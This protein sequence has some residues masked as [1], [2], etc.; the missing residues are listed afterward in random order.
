[1][2]RLFSIALACAFVW[3]VTGAVQAQ[4]FIDLSD[5]V[6]GGDGKGTGGG[7]DGNREFWGIDWDN[8]NF[9]GQKEIVIGSFTETDGVNPSP[10]AG[11]DLID[12]VFYINQQD[13]EVNSEGV[14][15]VFQEGDVFGS[16]HGY[17]MSNFGVDFPNTN[18]TVGGITTWESVIGLHAAAGVTFD[19]NEIRAAHG[20]DAVHTLSTFAG[21]MGCD[22]GGNP[23]SLFVIYSNKNGIVDDPFSPG[24]FFR[25][26]VEAN[27]GERYLGPIPAAAEFLTLAAGAT[28]G[29]FCCDGAGFAEPRIFPD[30]DI[31]ACA[32]FSVVPA[33]LNMFQPESRKF[34]AT[35]IDTLGFPEDVSDSAGTTYSSAD[36]AIATVSS[37][38][39]V[40][41]IASGATEITVSNGGSSI[42]VPVNVVGEFLNVSD[43]VAG[44][45]GTGL[46]GGPQ[47]DS[48][49]WAIEPDT[50]EFLFQEEVDEFFGEGN[51]FGQV[52]TVDGE[53]PSPVEGSDF[54]D[55]TLY[56]DVTPL[57]INSEGVLFDWPEND[58]YPIGAGPVQSNTTHDYRQ[59]DPVI[60]IGGT[61]DW[62]SCIG[63][64]SSMG[65]TFDLE[66]LRGE[67]GADKIHTFSTVFGQL[68]NCDCGPTHPASGFVIYSDKDGIVPDPAIAGADYFRVEAIT[69]EGGRYLGRIPEEAEFL[70]LATG[71]ANADFCCDWAGFAEPRILAESEV[72]DDCQELTAGDLLLLQGEQARIDVQCTDARGFKRN[73]S[74]AGAGST[75]SVVPEGIVTV[76]ADGLVSVVA[77]GE[78]DVTVS[79]MG[80]SV[81]SKVIVPASPCDSISVD[82]ASLVLRPGDVTQL[83]VPCIDLLGN[84]RDGTTGLG[85]VY[86]SDSPIVTVNQSGLVTG[87]SLGSANITVTNGDAVATVSA[88]VANFVDLGDVVAGGDGF[89]DGSGLIGDSELV[90]LDIDTGEFVLQKAGGAT[91]DADGINPSPVA[92]SDQVDVVFFIDE[93]VTPINSA[94]VE[95]TFPENDV[96]A[97]SFDIILSNVTHD[98]TLTVGPRDDWGSAVGIHAAAGITFDLDVVRGQIGEK[99]N[100]STFAGM[101]TCDC[102]PMTLYVIFS[103]DSE[104][105]DELTFKEQVNARQGS[106]FEAAIPPEATFL[107]LAAGVADGSFCCDGGGFAEPR[108][109]AVT[110]QPFKRGDANSDGGFDLSDS[111]SV[112]NFLFIGGAAPACMKAADIDDRGSLDL[113][114]G[115]FGL[116]ALFA[117]GPT[118]PAPFDS[119]GTD[120]TPDDLSCEAFNPCQ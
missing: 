90:G 15:I 56:M 96:F 25:I 12:A 20:A 102:D 14:G 32:E 3:G 36:T 34:S 71:S 49:V 112:L 103:N 80:A 115:V 84:E 79:R 110:E 4:G 9:L 86:V 76:D 107:T 93:S 11:S 2:G 6:A 61:R 120:P 29:D 55:V 26:E 30:M 41:S 64:H 38:G 77:V 98:G 17:L 88:T 83:S 99:L 94:G 87:V 52:G 104:V 105:L 92:E 101:Y 57:E 37:T 42:V 1:M 69:A 31:N 54:V 19:L 81:V 22:C 27:Q 85:T 51:N 82:P 65:V 7:P 62:A 95:Y 97:T 53:N 21:E 119:C 68:T 46:G 45:D 78:A 91:S 43:L 63:L 74:A 16:G 117:G 106:Q 28:D 59:G 35:C 116:N 8:G 39:V 58:L 113:T 33:V 114:D 10:V 50:G 24:S 100:F 73:V 75:Y 60:E 44:G 48:D 89:G 13:I 40:V 111:V 5:I 70:T 18:R 118:P 67:H 47:G 66:E 23:V 109:V 108:I 72:D